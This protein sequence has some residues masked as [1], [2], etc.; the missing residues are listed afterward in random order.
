[1]P[2]S[3]SHIEVIARGVLRRGSWL[4][5][6]K[7]AKGGYSYLPGGHVEFG[8]A[9]AVALA[10]ELMEEAGLRVRVRELV[11][12]SEGVFQSRGERHHELNLVF[13]VKHDRGAVAEPQTPPPPVRSLER[14]IE[15]EWV[16]LPELESIDL[17]PLSMRSWLMN[18]FKQGSPLNCSTWNTAISSI[19][20]MHKFRRKG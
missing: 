4:L 18:W 19:P 1:M 3:K 16:Q 9:A 12:A 7:N 5:V 13:H 14:H 17:R 6:C 20:R 8:E 2:K 15:F 10:R 11:L